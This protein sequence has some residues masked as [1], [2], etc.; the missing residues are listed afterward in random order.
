MVERILI[1]NAILLF[2]YMCAWFTAAKIRNRLDTVDTAWGL[3][4]V[5]AAWS[6]AVQAP[7]NRSLLIAAIVSIWGFRLAN[8]IWQRGKTKGEDPR[9]TEIA[10]KW[11]GN[12]W[13]RA[14]VS[15]FMTQC[16]LIWIVSLPIVLAA[17]TPHANLS[18]LT[19]LG[20]LI[21]LDGFIIE[22]VA[23]HQ[24]AVFLKTKNHPKLLQTGLWKYSRHP[25]YLGELTMWWG[26]GVI[27]LQTSYG[28]IGLI[29]PLVLS[30]L[31]IGISGI[32]PIERR[33]SKDPEYRA[34]M[35]RTSAL[36][37]LPQRKT[38]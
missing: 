19:I 2:A 31:I 15:I 28:Y 37:I 3:G 26:I 14:F 36:F 12:L 38:K 8:H 22:A 16:A 24:L 32:P 4:F 18:W 1:I 7:S 35:R 29:G 13:A 21:W 30:V 25:N 9:Y 5:V 33:K 6:V 34:Y 17:G 10:E 27:A 23:D 11:K 20:G